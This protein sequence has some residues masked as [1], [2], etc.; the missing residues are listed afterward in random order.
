MRVPFNPPN[1]YVWESFFRTHAVQHPQYGG[2]SAL[3]GAFRGRQY[4]RGHGL[5]SVL[6]TLFKSI[7]PVAK[8]VGK[9]VGKEV[10]RTSAHVASDALAGQDIGQAFERRGRQS[11]AKLLNKGIS[12]LEGG[13]TVASSSSSS[14]SG[15]GKKKSSVGRKKKRVQKGHGIGFMPRKGSIKRGNRRRKLIRRKVKVQDQLGSYFA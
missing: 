7:L 2:G 13:A 4:Q 12:K 5:G 8:K 6:G 15:G 10:L 9:S 14:S 11:A 3:G 1:P